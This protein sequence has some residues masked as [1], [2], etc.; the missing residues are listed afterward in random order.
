MTFCCNKFQS[1]YEDNSLARDGQVVIERFPSIKIVK[2]GANNNGTID[3]PYRFL[4]I[5]GLVN[6]R[7]PYINI[8]YCP[9][10]GANLFNFYKSDI[11]INEKGDAFFN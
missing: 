11:Y 2:L 9:F 3:K 1:Y 7:P 4:I 6:D 5:S 10:C 8:A